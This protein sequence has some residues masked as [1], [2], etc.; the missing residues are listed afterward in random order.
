MTTARAYAFSPPGAT[1][2]WRAT[3]GTGT[4]APGGSGDPTP[5]PPPPGGTGMLLGWSVGEGIG[6]Q[7]DPA[8]V[9]AAGPATVIRRYRSGTFANSWDTDT[10]GLKNDFTAGRASMYSCK[11][12]L[13]LLVS[14]SAERAR[15]LSFVRSAPDAAV[16]FWEFWHELDVKMRKGEDPFKTLTLTQINAGKLIAYDIVKQAAKP[17]QYTHLCMSNFAAIGNVSVGK[18]EQFWVGPDGA[19]RVIDM[20]TWDVYLSADTATTG[21]HEFG[22][23]YTFCNLHGTALGVGEMG[24]HGGAGNVT[25]FSIVPGWMQ[26]QIDYLA[27]HDAGGHKGAA[28][29]CWFNSSNQTALPVPSLTA[30]TQAKSKTLSVAHYLPPADFRM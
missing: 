14:S 26:T 20:V 15:L 4:V 21:S 16:I 1:A 5:P 9:S 7:P 2:L 23:C 3:N 6:N 18:P 19:D 12:D 22:P 30:D 13:A 28:A 29:V 25:D 8:L 17:H 27:S 11:P 24:I 10:S